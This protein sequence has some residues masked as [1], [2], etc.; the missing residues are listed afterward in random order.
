MP[1]TKPVASAAADAGAKRSADD[2]LGRARAAPTLRARNALMCE[3]AE[4]RREFATAF[5][6]R[7]GL[8]LARRAFGP[9][10]LARGARPQQWRRLDNYA[11]WPP[12][13]PAADHARAF[14]DQ[15]G[16]AA[17]VACHNYGYDL[18]EIRRFADEHGLLASVDP[19]DCA[20]WWGLDTSLVVYTSQGC[21]LDGLVAV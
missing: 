15:D 17:M 10:S 1:I 7:W 11:G 8:R 13:E 18:D 3:V 6:A 19:A 20:G 2:L 9:Q 14:V 16:R 5:G 4:L 21:L 12:D